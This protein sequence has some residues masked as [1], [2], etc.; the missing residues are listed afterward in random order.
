MLTHKDARIIASTYLSDHYPRDCAILSEQWIDDPPGWYFVANRLTS[1]PLERYVGDGGFFVDASTAEIVH[2]S[3][4]EVV[5]D[6]LLWWIRARKRGFLPGNY[7]VCI[8]EVYDLEKTATLLDARQIWR[9]LPELPDYF[10]LRKRQN[11]HLSKQAIITRL[12]ELPCLLEPLYPEEIV[13]I[14]AEFTKASCCR[15]TY[16]HCASMDT[17]Q[18]PEPEDQNSSK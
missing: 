4:G 6:T 3:S 14:V 1:H 10:T 7:R 11:R 13:E 12:S 16:E 9:A 17:H 15:F 5:G 18:L 8:L 2:L